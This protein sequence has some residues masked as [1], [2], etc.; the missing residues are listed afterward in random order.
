[1]QIVVLDG[2]A[3]NPGDLSWDCFRA[4]GTV[5]V[6][7]RTPPEFTAQRL[8]GADVAFTNKTAIGEAELERAK[9]LKMIGILATGYD[10]I[11]L[12]A[13]TRRGIVVCNAP[14]YSTDAVVQHTFALLLEI[15][16]QVAHH[17]REVHRGR[18]T[19]CADF[20]FWDLPLMELSGKTFGVLGCGEI[21]CA[22]ARAAGAFGMRVIGNSRGPHPEFCGERVSLEELF[23]RS[24]V[25]S[26]H[27]PATE[28]TR[29]IVNAGTLALMKDGAILLNTARGALC[30]PQDVADA[31]GSGKLYACAMD[32][33]EREPIARSNPLLSAKNCILTPH[34]AWAPLE[35]RQRLLHI[36]AENLRAFLDGAPVNRVN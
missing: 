27:C 23:R 2:H 11:D 31:L 34:I 20:C 26:L 16:S 12:A 24:D 25:L 28:E 4:F 35:T 6:Y 32:V 1:M 19:H 36:A 21:G 14:S 9:N 18:W 33:A 15:C 30:V 17:N 29:G 8:I 3:L 7:D 13:A 5:S 10:M 22:V